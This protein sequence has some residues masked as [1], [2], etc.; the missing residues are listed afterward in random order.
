MHNTI[1]VMIVS[2][3]YLA[4]SHRST[5]DLNVWSTL[6]SYHHPIVEMYLQCYTICDVTVAAPLSK[7]TCSNVSIPWSLGFELERSEQLGAQH[8]KRTDA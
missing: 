1:E 5:S 6:L 2:I 8:R 3:G 7:S 4:P